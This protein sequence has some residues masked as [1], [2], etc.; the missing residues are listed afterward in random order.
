[1]TAMLGPEA[2]GGD[3]DEALMNRGMR[4]NEAKKRKRER[5][6]E[7]QAIQ[8]QLAAE[9]GGTVQMKDETMD[10]PKSPQKSKPVELVQKK[11]KREATPPVPNIA[12]TPGADASDPSSKPAP[13]AKRLK[14]TIPAVTKTEPAT[15]SD[16]NA[17]VLADP[18]TLSPAVLTSSAKSPGPRSRHGS[19]APE[20]TLGP[21]KSSTKITIKPSKAASAEPPARRVSLRRGSNASLPGSGKPASPAPE[22]PVQTG[23]NG[24]RKRPA[25]GLVTTEEDG[26]AKVIVGKRKAA[27]RKK[28]NKKEDGKDAQP[29]PT[30]AVEPEEYIDP[31]EARYCVC[32]DVSWGTMIACDNDDVS[33]A[34]V[35][36]ILSFSI[37]T[38]PSAKR[39]GSISIAST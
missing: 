8:A 36:R 20:G 22:A 33:S 18:S 4:L 30:S 34:H 23:R 11:R 26:S 35:C 10:D 6:L 27:P 19:S 2:D 37:L 29:A 15:A 1:M 14:I 28:N 5:Q 32:G 13:P 39:N 38:L 16:S 9:N 25:P 31:N 12:D 17:T 7:E 21:R 3:G 24:R